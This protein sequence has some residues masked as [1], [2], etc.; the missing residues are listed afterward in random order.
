MIKN[1]IFD[2]GNV[3]LKFNRNYLLGNFYQGEDFAFLKEKI[4]CDWELMDDDTITPEEHLERVLRSLPEKYHGIAVN[5][6]T[7]WEEFM[8]YNDATV[9][10]LKRLKADGF[11]L[12]VLSNMTRHFIAR[13]SLFPFFELFDGIVYSAP[14]KTLKPNPEIY[15]H[16]LDKYSLKPEECIF[17]DDLEENLTAADKF[18]IKTFLFKDNLALLEKFIYENR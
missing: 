17:T 12:Y 14:I 15:R 1:V 4:F 2:I 10:L 11:K 5:V 9:R 3:L 16:I 6:L 13:E 18:G 7:R 8:L